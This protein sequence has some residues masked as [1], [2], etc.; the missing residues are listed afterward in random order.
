MG[1]SLKKMHSLCTKKKKKNEKKTDLSHEFVMA[2][3][4]FPGQ[5]IKMHVDH[6][7]KSNNGGKMVTPHKSSESSVGFDGTIIIFCNSFFFS[8]QRKST[9]F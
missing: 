5:T 1:K 3:R 9:N 6:H 8:L 2:M 7:R 4:W